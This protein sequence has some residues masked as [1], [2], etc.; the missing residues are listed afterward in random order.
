[1][2]LPR[3]FKNKSPSKDPQVPFSHTFIS[4]DKNMVE[5]HEITTFVLLLKWRRWQEGA[6]EVR[7][8]QLCCGDVLP[9]ASLEIPGSV[10]ERI[11]IPSM[12]HPHGQTSTSATV[13]SSQTTDR[14]IV[15]VISL[16]YITSFTQHKNRSLT[17]IT[18][19]LNVNLPY[20]LHFQR[21]IY[22]YY[23]IFTLLS[24][25][26]PSKKEKEQKATGTDEWQRV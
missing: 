17:M 20:I 15:I 14:N 5:L 12:I 18:I 19:F 4:N 9:P 25:P 1:M 6:R 22:L 11:L 23:F 2:K 7:F 8:L 3:H 10:L 13:C 26:F 16:S 21:N 24:S